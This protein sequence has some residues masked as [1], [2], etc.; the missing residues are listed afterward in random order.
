MI[1]MQFWASLTWHLRTLNLSS[2]CIDSLSSTRESCL[3]SCSCWTEYSCTIFNRSLNRCDLRWW[4]WNESSI[5]TFLNSSFIT[6][7]H[8]CLTSWIDSSFWRHISNILSQWIH[9]LL[10][11]NRCFD[12]LDCRVCLRQHH[13]DS[14]SILAESS[15]IDW[16]WSWWTIWEN[17]CLHSFIHSLELSKSSVRTSTN[18]RTS[19]AWCDDLIMLNKNS[20]MSFKFS[21]IS[22]Y[23]LHWDL[24]CCCYSSSSIQLLSSHRNSS[25]SSF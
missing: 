9:R 13:V 3:E 24:D 12:W 23:C 8:D 22:I 1:V 15:W 6:W 10:S 18:C 17:N 16:S 19:C 20:N 21:S 2:T 11:L 4:Y 5:R 7:D 14:S 25:H